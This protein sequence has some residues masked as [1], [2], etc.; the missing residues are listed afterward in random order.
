MSETCIVFSDPRSTTKVQLAT[1]DGQQGTYAGQWGGVMK[2]QKLKVFQGQ[3]RS[4]TA[5]FE[6][7]GYNSTD[8]INNWMLPGIAVFVVDLGKLRFSGVITKVDGDYVGVTSQVFKVT[9][10]SDLNWLAN[11]TTC[12]K[13][14]VDHKQQTPKTILMDILDPDINWYGRNGSQASLWMDDA[15]RVDYKISDKPVLT[16]IQELANT[17][18]M[19][20]RSRTLSTRGTI[21]AAFSNGVPVT[22][23]KTGGNNWITMTASTVGRGTHNKWI[24]V[25]ISSSTEPWYH[26]CACAVTAATSN[27]DSTST[28]TPVSTNA[29]TFGGFA[30]GRTIL[31]IQHPI[32]EFQQSFMRDVGKVFYVNPTSNT[33]TTVALEYSPLQEKNDIVTKV[34]VSGNDSDNKP[35][36]VAIAAAFPYDATIGSPT[37]RKFLTQYQAVERYVH[38]GYDT[39]CLIN[40]S[41]YSGMKIQVYNDTGIPWDA[42]FTGHITQSSGGLYQEMFTVDSV[43]DTGENINGRPTIWLTLTGAL[44]YSYLPGDVV[45]IGDSGY[46]VMYVNTTTYFNANWYYWIGRELVKCMGINYAGTPG[47]INVMRAIPFISSQ[48]YTTR[49]FAGPHKKYCF[50]SEGMPPDGTE[51]CEKAFERDDYFTGTNPSPISTYGVNTKPIYL[52][53]ATDTGTMELVAYNVLRNMCMPKSKGSFKTFIQALNSAYST[54]DEMIPG[55]WFKVDFFGTV[56]PSSTT[57]YEIMSMDMDFDSRIVDVQ[58]DEYDITLM[59]SLAQMGLNISI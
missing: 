16:Q 6:I 28:I 48:G 27:T 49:T 4:P 35:V 54:Y 17:T 56:H 26:T 8:S 47:A 45:C 32:L 25:L 7:F 15:A 1:R 51:L 43:V 31:L 39:Q 2:F 42:A 50:I 44:T 9:C 21:G 53:K 10:E 38:V 33:Y 23:T 14:G 5:T 3:N 20:F 59:M 36:S 37:Y 58:F 13:N 40:T 12:T 52:N 57:S 24:A 19:K 30:S 11:R 41:S 29:L 34:I 18:G 22:L 55:D 46:A